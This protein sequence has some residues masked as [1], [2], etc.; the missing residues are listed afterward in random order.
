MMCRFQLFLH[1]HF[2]SR[3]DV[4]GYFTVE[5]S[6]LMLLIIPVL[7]ALLLCGFYVHDNAFLQGAAEEITAMGSNLAAYESRDS[8]LQR[9]LRQRVSH[10]MVWTRSVRSSVSCSDTDVQAEAG[11]TFPVPGLAAQL[12]GVQNASAGGSADRHLIRPARIIW[13]IRGAEYLI[14]QTLGE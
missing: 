8:L 14:D 10:T 9:T 4:P 13:K 1:D 3:P 7:T 6:L 11:G 5:A 2:F 12:F